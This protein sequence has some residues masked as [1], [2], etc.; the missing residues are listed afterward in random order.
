MGIVPVAPSTRRLWSDGDRNCNGLGLRRL[1]PG[2]RTRDSA[3]IPMLTPITTMISNAG[4]VKSRKTGRRRQ[5]AAGAF[6]PQNGHW[7]SR[8]PMSM[9]QLGQSIEV[10]SFDMSHPPCWPMTSAESS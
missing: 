9:R 7:D 3:N 1:I 5:R 6:R 10:R 8:V 2:S 4:S